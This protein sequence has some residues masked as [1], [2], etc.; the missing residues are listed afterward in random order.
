LWLVPVSGATVDR[1]YS[2]GAYPL[3]QR[4]MTSLSNFTGL[5]W[6]DALAVV[7][8]G[9]LIAHLVAAYRRSRPRQRGRVWGAFLLRV[10][11]CAAVLALWF[12]VSWGMNYRRSP[13]SAHLDFDRARVTAV[14]V[15][16]VAGIAA[17]ALNARHGPAHAEPWPA[18][19]ALLSRLAPAFTE[20][21]AL[22]G[23]PRDTV[24]GRPKVTLLGPW[25]RAAGIAGF[26]NPLLLEVMLTPDA[27]PFEQPSLLAH[28]WAHLAGLT[29]EAEAG[30]LGWLVCMHGDTQAQYSGWLELLPRLV[31]N[32]PPEERRRVTNSLGE[33]VKSDYRAIDARLRHVRPL[34][35]DVAWAGYDRFL[36]AHRVEGGVQSY[37]AVVSFVAGTAFDKEWRPRVRR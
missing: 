20:G 28:E 10:V 8:A 5:A 19:R 26:T 3:W 30:F 14:R 1:V 33:G 36:K 22:L 16:E 12:M 21:K 35:R 23:L 7:I 32:L 24:P 2:N 4:V 11:A 25:F 6:I 31:G 17:A 37:D 18:G 13:L 9:W 27:L 34:A 15:R 29:N